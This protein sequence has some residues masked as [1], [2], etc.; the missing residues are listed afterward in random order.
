MTL[1]GMLSLDTRSGSIFLMYTSMYSDRESLDADY[2]LC[3]SLRAC[4]TR[5]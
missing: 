1:Q 3:V 4:D 5:V 2:L